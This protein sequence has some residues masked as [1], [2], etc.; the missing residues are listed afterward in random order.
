MRT[1]RKGD[2]GGSLSLRLFPSPLLALTP[3]DSFPDA[4][5]SAHIPPSAA[6]YPT[7]TER[8]W[9][10]TLAPC[11]AQVTRW[12]S[13]EQLPRLPGSGPT[14]WALALAAC[15]QPR[16][17]NG[18]SRVRPCSSPWSTRTFT[19][20]SCGC[21]PALI[22]SAPNGGHRHGARSHLG[23]ELT[24]KAIPVVSLPLPVL[25]LF[26]NLYWVLQNHLPFLSIFVVSFLL[27][28]LLGDALRVSGPWLIP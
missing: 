25:W 14:L 27:L 2:L 13:P 4:I 8:C 1:K 15:S 17:G 12:G 11:A 7:R 9:V 10:A 5:L 24:V 19:L 22:Q 20:C 23:Q 6:C 26:R 18:A 21:L 16:A 3:P 28:L